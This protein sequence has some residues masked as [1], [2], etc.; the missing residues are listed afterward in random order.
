MQVLKAV[1]DGGYT[2][3]AFGRPK[4]R[5]RL[6]PGSGVS[7]LHVGRALIACY[8]RHS[9]CEVSR[10][11]TLKRSLRGH[12]AP[13]RPRARPPPLWSKPTARSVSLMPHVHTV[14]FLMNSRRSGITLNTI[15]AG[16]LSLNRPTGSRSHI[17]RERV[18]ELDE[19]ASSR[20]SPAREPGLPSNLRA[21][22]WLLVRNLA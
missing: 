7:L 1:S 5:R 10:V 3:P 14:H 21:K 2:E 15:L 11:A 19:S 4:L 17:D 9:G 12:A 13:S 16:V 20:Y 22:S 8:V 6:A 18:A